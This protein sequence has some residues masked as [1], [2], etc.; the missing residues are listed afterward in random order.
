MSKEIFTRRE[1]RLQ[2]LRKVH[3]RGL[4]DV[5]SRGFS[6]DISRGRFSDKAPVGRRAK[7]HRRR[8]LIGRQSQSVAENLE[9]RRLV[10][11]RRLVVD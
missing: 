4:S 2:I 7:P 5:L 3:P 8:V 11:G 9:A 1:A 6:R 10:R